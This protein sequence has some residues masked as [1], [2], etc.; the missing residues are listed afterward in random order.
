M[1]LSED[2]QS[3]VGARAS[4]VVAVLSQVEKRQLL[5]RRYEY[6]AFVF[7][8]RPGIEFSPSV[9]K[10]DYTFIKIR[11]LLLHSSYRKNVLLEQLPTQQCAQL[12]CPKHGGWRH[13]PRTV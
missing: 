10:H 9:Q 1:D 12:A 4:L 7:D 8:S 2:P 13:P 11:I 5:R 3:Q 6:D